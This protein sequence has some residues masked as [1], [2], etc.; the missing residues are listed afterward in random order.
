M[1]QKLDGIAIASIVGGT[2]FVYAGITG[3]SVLASIQAIVS[4]KSPSGL[5]KANPIQGTGNPNAA[6]V[7]QA[8]IQG[9]V[10][11]T[12]I[13]QDAVQYVGHAYRYGGAPGPSGTNP[14]DCSSFVN[15]VLNHDMHVNIPGG[16]WNPST[17]GP[18]TTSYSGWGGASV[19]ARGNAAA[20]DL[21]LWGTHIGICLNNSQMVS[22][23][24][25]HLGT[26]ITGIENGGP[27]GETL[28]ILRL[29]HV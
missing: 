14:W 22:A 19:V 15:W 8:S 29:S 17:H 1:A 26:R 2:I 23:L 13:A 20:G 5:A 6:P 28:R 11:G 9:S 7:G 21:A 27:Q 18:N 4:G 25:E 12:A 3:R 10:N 16:N 24:N